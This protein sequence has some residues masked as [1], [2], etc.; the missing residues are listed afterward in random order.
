MAC[1]GNST[2]CGGLGSIISVSGTITLVEQA[3]PAQGT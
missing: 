2:P 1:T 3:K